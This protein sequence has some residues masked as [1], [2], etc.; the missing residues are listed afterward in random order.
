[1]L[2]HARLLVTSL[3]AA[4]LVGVGCAGR[5]PNILLVVIDTARADRFPFDGYPRPTA[6]ALE[7]LARQGTV[8]TQAYS[9]APWTVPAHASLFTGQYPS[10]HRTDCGSLRLP[11]A[12]V[13][14]AEVLRA[15]GYHTVG[16]TANPWIGV[17]Y[18]FQQGFDTYGEIW[19]EVQEGSEDTGASLTNLRVER[20]LR[21]RAGNADARRRPF[22]LFINYFEPHLP[23]HPPE[24][25]R[26]RLLRPGADPARVAR[27]SHLGH[28]DEMRFIMGR[29]DLTARDLAI[30]NDLYDGEIA[31]V[32]RRLGE[33]IALLRQ[34]GLLDRTVVAVTADHGENIGDHGML[35]HKM[36][37]HDTLL[38]VPLLLRYPGRV[39]AGQV[40]DRLVQMHDLFPTLLQLA[41]VPPPLDTTVEARLLPGTDSHAPGRGPDDPIVGEFVGPP[42]DFLRSMQELFPKDDLSRFNRKL[43]ALRLGR[44]KIQWGSDGRHALFDVADDPGE[45]HDLAAERPDLL[46]RM[47]DAVEAWLNRPA[48]RRS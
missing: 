12:A 32:D 39:P 5:P 7:E 28:P 48:R 22:F 10:L 37:V 33:V 14:L 3:L 46:R 13:T 8:Y 4:L 18:N 17:A 26:S 43:V 23:Y 25:E 34:E 15:A 30:L 16:Y 47:A 40:V 24:P 42:V 20:F 2:S 29:S 36:S 11:D 38:H 6:P 35:D 44:Y 21:W 31:Y 9:P 27:L 19:R 45:T 1:M 41:G